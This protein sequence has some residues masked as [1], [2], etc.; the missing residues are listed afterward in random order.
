MDKAHIIQTLLAAL[1]DDLHRLQAA[2]AQAS[3]GATHSETRAE[4]KWDTCGLEA[5]YLARGHAEKFRELAAQV[6]ELRGMAPACFKKR[7]IA[8]GA[9]AK[10]EMN[11]EIMWFMIL[12]YGGGKDLVID[13][14]EVTVI[15]PE[16]PIGAALLDKKA[17]DTFSFRAGSEGRIISVA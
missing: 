1:E 6:H 16:S 4:T 13:G 5:S 2:N 10:V 11:G 3:S 12:P 7:P 9:L 8:S 14:S 17:S 15:T